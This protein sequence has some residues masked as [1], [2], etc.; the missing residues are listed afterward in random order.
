MKHLQATTKR[1][2][3]SDYAI[4]NNIIYIKVEYQDTTAPIFQRKYYFLL[5]WTH[6]KEPLYVSVWLS[7][8]IMWQEEDKLLTFYLLSAMILVH[9]IFQ[10]VP[11]LSDMTCIHECECSDTPIIWWKFTENWRKWIF[12]TTK[13]VS[14]NL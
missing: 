13:Y 11:C 2:L 10:K 6:L 5:P 7:Y 1:S 9:L 3:L 12:L 8:S 4:Y 14:K